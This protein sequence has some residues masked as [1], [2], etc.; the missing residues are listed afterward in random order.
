MI[1]RLNK[2]RRSGGPAHDEQLH[3]LFDILSKNSLRRSKLCVSELSVMQPRSNFISGA[4]TCTN[5]I[6]NISH[7][8]FSSSLSSFSDHA[9]EL[10]N[11]VPTKPLIFM[12][13]PSSF[14]QAGQNIEVN[15]NATFARYEWKCISCNRQIP[16]G[17]EEIHHEVELGVVIGQR[18][19]MYAI[20]CT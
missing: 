1:E 5:C 2:E 7:S 20:Q 8:S 19:S 17:C 16:Q 14:I 12:K 3:A 13:P 6:S 11:A 9:A 15:R 18:G 10:G 4:G